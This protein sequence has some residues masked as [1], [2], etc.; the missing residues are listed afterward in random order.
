MIL[1]VKKEKEQ[2]TSSNEENNNIWLGG[3][4]QTTDTLFPSG[5]YAHSYGLEER[6]A[7]GDIRSKENLEDFLHHEILPILKNLELPYLRF[8][9][10]KVELQEYKGL[11]QLNDEISAW[12]L[13]REIREAGMSQGTQMIRMIREIYQC[14]ITQKFEKLI[15]ETGEKPQQITA[16]A[17]LRNVQNV[18]LLSTLTAWVYQAVSNFCSASVKLLRLGEVACQKIIHRCLEPHQLS[19]LLLGSMEVK[20]KNAG[21]FNPVMDIASA[22]HELAFSRLFIS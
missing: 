21:F 1:E 9:F 4:L 11:L 15:N 19:T 2:K 14:P 16:T 13:T 6:V 5:G 3:L 17:L 7:L 8:C 22:R 18:P 12:K 10:S 20:E